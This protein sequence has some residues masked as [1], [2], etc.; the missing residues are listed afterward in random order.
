[1]K[2][3]LSVRNMMAKQ[4][5]LS[6]E[7]YKEVDL[8]RTDAVTYVGLVLDESGSM[9]YHFSEAIEG[10]NLQLDTLRRLSEHEVR[11]WLNFFNER[12]REKLVGV[13]VSSLKN[14]NETNY[15]PGGGTA[16]LDG[17]GRTISQLKENDKGDPKSAFLIVAFSDGQENESRT[18]SWK[19]LGVEVQRLQNTGRW[20]FVFI[21]P[22]ANF[23]KF[24]DAGFT[25][26]LDFDSTLNLEAVLEKNAEALARYLRARNVGGLLPAYFE[27]KT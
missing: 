12:V 24:R 15:Q 19:T 6:K 3:D 26:L 23:D 25:E 16:L 11:V 18:W 1:M 5:A 20:T 17:I 10:F 21:G 8:S 13:P 27:E 2:V 7:T 4:Q 9:D 14:L 22:R